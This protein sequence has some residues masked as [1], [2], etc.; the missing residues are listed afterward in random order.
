MSL[1]N[2]KI[3]QLPE[4]Y[5]SNFF[6]FEKRTT[7][8]E[9][10]NRKKWVVKNFHIGAKRKSLIFGILEKQLLSGAYTNPEKGKK[11]I[12]IMIGNMPVKKT[13]IEFVFF[14][15]LVFIGYSCN[16]QYSIPGKYVRSYYTLELLPD[17]TYKYKQSL[18]S[19]NNITSDGTWTINKDGIIILNSR[20]DVSKISI[21]VQEE[22]HNIDSI[23][24]ELRPQGGLYEMDKDYIRFSLYIDNQEIIRQKDRIIKIPKS[25]EFSEFFV[26]IYYGFPTETN[27]GLALDFITLEKYRVKSQMC[28]YFIIDFPLNLGMYHYLSLNNDTIVYKN[29]KLYW[30]NKG[31]FKKKQ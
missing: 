20:I 5:N 14:I 11:H 22:F 7:I 8:F 1:I 30:K 27:H 24:I 4:N 25:L 31:V 26:R 3:L 29:K 21:E 28:N 17:S 19:F 18:T 9:H 10:N 15:I 16:T 6:E 23:S 12:V 13:K 2:T